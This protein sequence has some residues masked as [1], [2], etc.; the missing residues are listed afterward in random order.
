MNHAGGNA[1]DSDKGRRLLGQRPGQADQPG[2]GGGIGGFG[3]AARLPPDGG[4]KTGDPGLL[5][6]THCQVRDAL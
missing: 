3:A 2:L 6:K 5:Q 1:V 4:N